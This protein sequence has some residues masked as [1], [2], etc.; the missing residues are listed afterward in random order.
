MKKITLKTFGNTN[1]SVLDIIA[2][3]LS[4]L[5][6]VTLWIET[7]YFQH[8]SLQIVPEGYDF[9]S[10]PN[11]YWASKMTYSVPFVATILYVGLTLY[12]QRVQ[13]GDY[14][15]ELSD[16]KAPA[17]KQINRRLW[18]WLKL[19]ILLMFVVVEYFS[20]HTGS[21]AGSGI[22]GWF[23]FVFPLLLFTPVII[24][25]IEFSKNQLE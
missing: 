13:H 8:Q 22:S 15:V 12:N 23:I 10:N 17:L 2:E 24:F 19:N 14:A 16:K 5:V 6:L 4:I 18:R 20:F 21:N 25:F 7:Y 1:L 3:I 9:F 11:E